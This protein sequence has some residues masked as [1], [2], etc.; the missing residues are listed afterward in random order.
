LKFPNRQEIPITTHTQ[1]RL[2]GK[3]L[4]LEA[5]WQVAHMQSVISAFG[6]SSPS[7]FQAANVEPFV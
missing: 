5:T 3:R 6:F 2:I 7:Y 4:S 1:T